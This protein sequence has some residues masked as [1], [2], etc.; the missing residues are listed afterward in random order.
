MTDLPWQEENEAKDD[1][2]DEDKYEEEFVN[3]DEAEHKIEV[4]WRK[5]SMFY[6]HRPRQEENEAKDDNENE[7]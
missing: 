2:L 5:V 7:D 3:A 6:C 1:Y 4:I